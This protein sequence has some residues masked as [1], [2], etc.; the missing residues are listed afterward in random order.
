MYSIDLQA[1]YARVIRGGLSDFARLTLRMSTY[2]TKRTSQ[3][4]I[5]FQGKVKRFCAGGESANK[6]EAAQDTAQ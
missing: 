2:G 5:R 4:D 1:Q 6:K 3:P